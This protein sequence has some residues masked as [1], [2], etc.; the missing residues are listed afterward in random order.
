MDL[1]PSSH[2]FLDNTGTV[3]VTWDIDS[4]PVEQRQPGVAQR[5]ILGNDNVLSEFNSRA[6]SGKDR[7]AIIQIVDVTD[8]AAEDD[9]GIVEQV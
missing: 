7:R 6:A 4:E 5:S 8:V 3:A 1:V 9:A 2:Q